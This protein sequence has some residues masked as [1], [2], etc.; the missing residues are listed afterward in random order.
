MSPASQQNKV[1]HTERYCPIVSGRLPSIVR[2]TLTAICRS[3]CQY[4]SYSSKL[5]ITNL[6]DVWRDIHY[7]AVVM[8]FLKRSINV[9]GVQE[10]RCTRTRGKRKEERA[11]VN[12]ARAPD[13]TDDFYQPAEGEHSGR[14]E[15]SVELFAPRPL[16]VLTRTV[17][18]QGQCRNSVH[19]I[20][21][22]LLP[23]Q[24]RTPRLVYGSILASVECNVSNLL[25]KLV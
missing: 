20:P 13:L 8:Y 2:R 15:S 6:V 21:S 9:D 25:M 1:F 22:R 24:L 10:L 18:H 16:R 17:S 4:G 3:M 11:K 12:C 19:R 23:L 14:P 7:A 5:A